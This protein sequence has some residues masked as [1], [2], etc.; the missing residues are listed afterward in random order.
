MDGLLARTYQ[1]GGRKRLVHPGPMAAAMGVPESQ[2]ERMFMKSEAA[3]VL[4]PRDAQ[5]R[6]QVLKPP[7]AAAAAGQPVGAGARS[8]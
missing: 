6:R 7:P 5:G 8:K 1:A 2:V 4:G 3:G